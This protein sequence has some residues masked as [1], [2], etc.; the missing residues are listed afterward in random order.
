M[1]PVDTSEDQFSKRLLNSLLELEVVDE[2]QL[3]QAYEQS[4]KLRLPFSEY[5]LDKDIISDSHLGTLIA[6]MH[7]LPYVQLS[8]T[9]VQYQVLEK[10]PEEAARSM[11]IVAFA[12]TDSE[13]SIAAHT[14]LPLQ[15]KSFLERK[16]GLSVVAY[17]ATPRDIESTYALYTREFQASFDT[18]ISQ[19]VEKISHGAQSSAPIIEIMNS[20]IEF[21]FQN[22]ASD[23][24]IEPMGDHTIVRYRIDGLLQDITRL[25]QEIHDQLVLR[26][27]VMAK[28]RIDEHASTQDGKIEYTRSVIGSKQ[29]KVDLRVS[30]VPITD[31]EKVVIRVLSESSRQFALKDLGFSSED[32]LKIKE[33]FEKPYGMVLATGPTGSGKTT[34]LYAILKLLNSRDV[35]ITT[36]E[37]PVEYDIEG[38]NQIQVNEQTGI[39]FAKGLRSIVRQ[40]PDVI[41][42][43]EIRDEET[44][45]IAVNSALTGHLVLSSL[46]TNDAAT[47]LPRLLDLGVEPFLVSSTVSVVVAQRLVRQL[48][49][50][51]RF[52]IETNLSEISGFSPD[53]KQH[54]FGSKSTVR[55]Y[56][57]KG[58]EVCHQ[59]KYQ[60]RIGI[61]EVMVISDEI[62]KAIVAE[63]DAATITKLAVSE[64]MQT[65]FENGIQ[66]VKRGETTLEEIF[67]VVKQ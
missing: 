49:Q 55:L 64:G 29:D 5:L 21:A 1:A 23:I 19:N 26:V 63:S 61:F 34:T 48:C 24:H 3:R 2:S 11:G 65:L 59:T 13:V 4:V 44:A 31:G 43:G 15:T 45:D 6:D 35:N 7:Q 28:L 36:I 39:T 58:C 38:I 52:S 17:Y 50:H 27:K 51:C 32:T 62:R 18:L 9:P 33:V 22:R 20:I 10:I 41:L 16:F 53:Q 8:S 47:A 46:H 37:D 60:G 56:D 57:G 40:D 14:P 25:P 66:K 30:I 54:F 12:A 42:V 67:R